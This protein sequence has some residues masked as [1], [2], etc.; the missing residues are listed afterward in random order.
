MAACLHVHTHERVA[1]N[2][3]GIQ[4]A[5]AAAFC[6]GKE[7]ML[8]LQCIPGCTLW[9]TRSHAAKLH[10]LHR[11]LLPR[12]VCHPSAHVQ[13]SD[14]ALGNPRSSRSTRMC[15]RPPCKM[16]VADRKCLEGTTVSMKTHGLARDTPR[17]CRQDSSQPASSPR[18]P[19]L[20]RPRSSQQ[21]RRAAKRTQTEA[22]L[23]LQGAPGACGVRLPSFALPYPQTCPSPAV[24][25]C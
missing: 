22:N 8:A 1:G 25:V 16:R 12:S 19:G 3:V 15:R 13:Q 9:C 18:R 23:H 7:E 4:S 2:S 5:E 10:P 20:P 11:S 21:S 24:Y 17:N 14:R 6:L